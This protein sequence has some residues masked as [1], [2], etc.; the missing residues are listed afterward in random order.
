MAYYFPCKKTIT[1]V[2]LA[3]LIWERIIRYYRGIEDMVSN[4]G[5]VF[6]S[7]YWATFC[8]LLGVCRKLSTAF[9][10]QTDSQTERQN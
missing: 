5:S 7:E 10:L 8:Y 9:Y 2:L 1:A 6:T 3:D 4:R